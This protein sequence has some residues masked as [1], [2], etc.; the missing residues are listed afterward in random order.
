[1]AAR[2]DTPDAYLAFAS[3]HRLLLSVPL[4]IPPENEKPLLPLEGKV[5]PDRKRIRR[6]PYGVELYSLRG[7]R[8]AL[9]GEAAEVPLV[10]DMH[11]LTKEPAENGEALA[12]R[13][14]RGGTSRHLIAFNEARSLQQI[15]F[16]WPAVAIVETTSAPRSQTEVTCEHR[17]YHEPSAPFL[18]IFDLE[19]NEPFEPAPPVAHL[20]PPPGPCVPHVL[21]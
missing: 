16:R 1:M 21:R 14:V 12:V 2:F 18:A 3:P 17:E 5:Q 15:A 19:R 11:I 7:R 9:L 20:A 6:P 4:P 8:L 13:S 10:S